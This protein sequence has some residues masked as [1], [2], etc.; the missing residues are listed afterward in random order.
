[1]PF[2]ANLMTGERKAT[3]FLL[4][5]PGANT[6]FVTD[7]TVA[8]HC[9]SLRIAVCLATSSV[10]NLMMVDAGATSANVLAA[11][12]NGNVALTAGAL[13]TFS[14]PVTRTE[15]GEADDATGSNVINYNFQVETNGVINLLIVDE[16][17]GAVI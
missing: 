16:M 15:D 9:T 10:L 4:A 8:K 3:K 13:Y 7:F 2:T 5:A 6:D 11:G 12:L 14:V 1:M 17:V